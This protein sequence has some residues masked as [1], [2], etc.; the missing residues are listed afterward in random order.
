MKAIEATAVVGPDHMMV[1]QLP[2]DVAA[3]EHR[4]VVVIDETSAARPER[5]TP[6]FSAY[7]VGLASDSFTFRREDLYGDAV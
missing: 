6:R 3:G 5:P 1:V 7:P 2:P 4:V